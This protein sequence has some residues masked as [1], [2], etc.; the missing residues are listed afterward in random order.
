LIRK[1][2]VKEG[3]GFW[4]GARG[5]GSGGGYNYREGEKKERKGN[6]ICFSPNGSGSVVYGLRNSGGLEDKKEG[7]VG[8]RG[9]ALFLISAEK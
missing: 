7:K 1:R 8:G 4:H 5:K 6:L 3:L 9:G 2:E